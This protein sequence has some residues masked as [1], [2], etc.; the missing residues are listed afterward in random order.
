MKIGLFC[1]SEKR[2]D[3]F[4][5]FLETRGFNVTSNASHHLLVDEPL[6][7]VSL[8]LT[9][10]QPDCCIIASQNPCPAYR[11]DLL[12]P[13]PAA[14]V[15]PQNEEV[16]L[17]TIS[18]VQAGKRVYPELYT[19]LTVSERRTLRFVAQ[20]YTNKEVARL[21]RVKEGTIK[22]TLSAIYAKLHLTSRVQAAHYYF[23]NWHLLID[24][25]PPPHVDWRRAGVI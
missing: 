2:H 22:N 9:E 3:D 7:W 19:P 12:D 15:Y 23:G 18:V 13:K 1:G 20:G 21:R 10:L 11:L 4:A 17:K 24:W 16:L 8:K 6:G 25:V 5:M 14:L